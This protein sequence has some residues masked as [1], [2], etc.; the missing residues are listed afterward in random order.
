MSFDGRRRTA[1]PGLGMS[2]QERH[3]YIVMAYRKLFRNYRRLRRAYRDLYKM[4]HEINE[5]L[6]RRQLFIPTD[7]FSSDDS[8]HSSSEED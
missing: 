6:Q 2:N 7:R 1:L 8:D 4:V 5:S 3:D